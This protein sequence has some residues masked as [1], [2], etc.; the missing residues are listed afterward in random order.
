M[1]DY[2]L[3]ILSHR[4]FE[5]LIQAIATKLIPSVTVFGDGPDGGREAT[6]DGR[7][8]Y[9][10]T[11][12]SWDGY[13]VI[14]A[15]F[16]QRSIGS[17]SDG[18]WAV[19]QLKS[20]LEKYKKPDSNLRKP[21][22]YIYA[23]NVV[24]TPVSERGSKDRI[25]QILEDFK[26]E[27]SLRGYE[28]WDY[29]KIR[30]L[31]DIHE[32][33]RHS[34]AA[35]ITPGDVLAA[36]IQKLELKNHNFEETIFSFLQKELLS[37]E[38]VN[39][40]QAGHDV[41][42]RIPLASV[43]IDLRTRKDGYSVN[44]VEFESQVDYDDDEYA[45]EDGDRGFIKH[46]LEISSEKFDS[47][48]LNVQTMNQ[49]TEQPI[50]H[51]P[52]GR[53]VLI[54]GPG[55]GKTTIGQFIC[56]IFRAANVSRKPEIMLSSDVRK[57]MSLIGE[58][59]KEEG[60]ETYPIPRFPFR[61]V[62]NEYASALSSSS[63]PAV[64]SIFSYLSKQ[65]QRR[66]DQ[67]IDSVD[68]R[69]WIAKYPI[70]LIF[71]GL[72][73]VPSSSNREQVLHSIRDFWIDASNDNADI[74]AV[75]T[76]R[77]QGY[78]EDFSSDIYQHLWLDPLSPK[79]GRHF[80]KRLVD[81]R[82]GTDLNRKEK[83]LGR[84]E[85]SFDSES[86]SRLMRTPLQITIMTALVD[87]MG[88]PPEARWDLFNSYYE[89]IYQREVER[90]IPASI[91]L[92]RYRPDIKAIHNRV[93]LV[94]QMDSE[95][96]GRTDAK[97]TASRFYALVEGRLR[98]EGHEAT[99]LKELTDRIEEAALERLV[100]LVGLESGQIGFEIRSL[101]EF[102]AAECIMEATDGQVEERLREIAP[103]FNW[104]NVFL[105]ASGKC[106]AERQ[107]L[108]ANILALC[109]SLNEKEQDP[110]A[111]A[112]LMGSSTAIELLED[113]L[114]RHQPMYSRVL[115]RIAM[116]AMDSANPSV[117]VKLAGIYEQEFE[118]IYQEEIRYRL[119]D[120]RMASRY[121]A[122]HCLL[123]L[124][125]E[126]IEWAVNLAETN[127]PT[128]AT[129]QF[130]V[131]ASDIDHGRSTVLRNPWI[132][133]KV[134]RLATHLPVSDAQHLLAFGS[135]QRDQL[136]SQ[137]QRIMRITGLSTDQ[138]GRDIAILNTKAAAWN[139]FSISNISV[140]WI[141]DVE[142]LNA[143]HPTWSVYTSS[144]RLL[145]NL[146]KET[147]AKE[148][149]FLADVLEF[150]GGQHPLN[151]SSRIPWPIRAC[152]DM[153][154]SRS[155]MLILARRAAGGELG[156][157]EDWIAA[158]KRWL[159]TGVTREDVL[160]MSDD[161]LPFDK[162]M[163]DIGFPT[164]LSM[165]PSVWYWSD[166][167]SLENLLDIHA[168]MPVSKSR[169]FVA[170]LIQ[171][172]LL[173]FGLASARGSDEKDLSLDIARLQ[174]IYQDLRRGTL[175]PIRIVIKC[176]GNSQSDAENFFD[177][178]AARNNSFG[179][180]LPG[181]HWS[182]TDFE[183]LEE[184]IV[185]AK[186]SSV[187]FPVLGVLAEHGRQCDVQ[188][189]IPD[190]LTIEGIDRRVGALLV[191]LAKESW[192]TDKTQQWLQMVGNVLP[193]SNGLLDRVIDTLRTKRPEGPY[194]EKLLDN[195]GDFVTSANYHTM[196][197]YSDALEDWL[198]RRVS[199]LA[200]P[201][202]ATRFGLPEGIVAVLTAE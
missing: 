150:P 161:R 129:E 45:S 192:L 173:H 115:A 153:C 117:H 138:T 180:Y 168:A 189:S 20:E 196:Q 89:V 9:P 181:P 154:H 100:F 112:Y 30:A 76:S 61:I 98:E 119:N 52:R 34:Y 137:L 23:T 3:S 66:T 179:F 53:F 132:L 36:L 46:I 148:L 110:I 84:L 160:S 135:I 177:A 183:S 105:F 145:R 10:D 187:F 149:T 67:A 201:T 197:N 128:E 108:R 198:G 147:L 107:H 59:C 4:S 157:S 97:L 170:S 77:P 121:G 96:S 14:Q 156:D 123:S 155:E 56:Q 186:D 74:I 102:M 143:G 106:F 104:K 81:V 79:V 120:S 39:L 7:V 24:L 43:F 202:D 146:S 57:A 73:E 162:N 82:Y 87:R 94:L 29:D 38:F 16:R 158:E 28:V 193:D 134:E 118:A 184:V 176:L 54:G 41:S 174:S 37:D 111:G 165:W 11:E 47:Q 27:G 21:D 48:S 163:A 131:V 139:L 122:W 116:R 6:F 109:G 103:L 194:A 185:R 178:M 25:F 62:L 58:H 1:P 71:D 190:P 99:E 78:S 18:Q 65:I 17:Q 167:G 195:L 50:R 91:L 90:D 171:L 200:R 95:R 33:I 182:P 42:E 124:A 85:R 75:A 114:C 72:D 44:T 49:T 172:S 35:W 31:L 101:Q 175:I 12:N 63:E 93:G 32:G 69:K 83:V 8:N 80:A 68:L 51:I 60:I 169:S 86:T 136:T 125:G 151:W 126:G 40:E 13:G 64:N 166:D 199:K 142:E 152:I 191:L 15:K 141:R 133:Q 127:W 2:N 188:I 164:G 26:K 88:Q 5:Q 159:S 92:R 19:D 113:G 140:N 55:Q 144:A 130:N 22:Y 70:I